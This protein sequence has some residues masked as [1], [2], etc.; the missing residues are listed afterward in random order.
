MREIDNN[1]HVPT[2]PEHVAHTAVPTKSEGFVQLPC[3]S[4]ALRSY[5]ALSLSHTH[6]HWTH[7]HTNAFTPPLPDGSEL[8]LTDPPSVSLEDVLADS[9]S[10]DRSP[11]ASGNT[12]A[13]S[14]SDWSV[15]S[16]RGEEPLWAPRADADTRLPCMYE[17]THTHTQQQQQHQ[18]HGT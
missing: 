2:A 1:A 13:K 12:P 6:T 4:N 16:C 18:L 10:S 15:M 11:L 8:S 14:S 5:P 3:M 9:S 17:N 7:T